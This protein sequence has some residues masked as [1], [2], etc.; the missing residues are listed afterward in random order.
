MQ[1]VFLDTAEEDAHNEQVF[2]GLSERVKKAAITSVAPPPTRRASVAPPPTRRD[3][4]APPPTRRG[5]EA[6]LRASVAPP[7]ALAAPSR[8]SVA[9]PRDLDAPRRASVAPP[10]TCRDSDAPPPTRRA[11]VAPPRAS[12]APPPAPRASSSA[13]RDPSA[14]SLARRDSRDSATAPSARRA[15]VEMCAAAEA[16]SLSV[17]APWAAGS[18]MVG[19]PATTI[20]LPGFC[21]SPPTTTDSFHE[22]IGEWLG[23]RTPYLTEELRGH[24][25][26]QQQQHGHRTAVRIFSFYFNLSTT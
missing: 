15:H 5:S 10:P 2:E 21:Q 16:A 20:S 1:T 3:S 8:A 13:R 7:R 23:G 24:F 14:P 25:Q 11:P 26:E 19:S 4:D 9:P 18:E 22:V 12:V 17:L 6:P